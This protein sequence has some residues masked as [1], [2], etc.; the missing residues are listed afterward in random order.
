MRERD[1]EDFWGME[2]TGRPDRTG[3]PGGRMGRRGFPRGKKKPAK[4]QIPKDT[5]IEYKNL[6]LLQKFVTDR[7]K[8]VSRR[9]TGVSGKEQRHM[10]AA[11]KR[12]QYL[13]LLS[14]GASKRK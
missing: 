10:T 12:A 14:V 1:N 11:I 3:K 2:R 6:A 7:G 9:V 5:K 4:Y 8:I 13:G